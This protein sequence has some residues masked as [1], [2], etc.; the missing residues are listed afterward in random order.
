MKLRSCGMLLAFG[1][2]VLTRAGTAQSA[3]EA[4]AQTEEVLLK[5]HHANQMEIAAGKMAQQK[6]QSKDVK[7]FG[8]TLVTDHSA[9]D[10]KVTALAKEEK[11]KLP[12]SA[13]MPDDKM[14]QM[15]AAKGADFDRM[16]AADMLEDHKAAIDEVKAARDNTQDE[17]LK[18]L[19]VATLPVLEKHRDTAERLIDKLGPNAS[20]A[21]NAAT[22]T[23]MK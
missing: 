17:K 4:T 22:P 7:A 1:L 21:G 3:D 18:A 15:K 11:I 10:K 20:A 2:T 12:S 9:A 8:K 5:L 16:F 13:P 6:G 19:L 14:D 23:D